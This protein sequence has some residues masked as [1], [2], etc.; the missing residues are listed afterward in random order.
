MAKTNRS[1]TRGEEDGQAK[2]S[3]WAKLKAFLAWGLQSELMR[4]LL[5]GVLTT[6]VNFL[7]LTLLGESFG[8]EEGKNLIFNSLA[9]VISILFAF[10]INRGFVFHSSGPLWPEFVSFF[11]SRILISLI[12]DNG[13][14]A[15]FYNVLG[16]QAKVPFFRVP[17]AKLIGAVFVVLANYLVGKFLVFRKQKN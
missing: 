11:S 10:W 7:A 6:L 8:Y 1:H 3:L 9:I 4:Y 17:W 16:L 13:F 15:L 5:A 2:T 12:F 14:F